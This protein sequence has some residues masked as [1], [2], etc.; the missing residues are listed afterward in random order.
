MR[1]S[2]PAVSHPASPR[3]A[4]AAVPLFANHDADALTRIAAVTQRRQFRRGEVIFHRG[5]PGASLYIVAAGRVKIMVPTDDG[6]EMVLT[7]MRPGDFFGE[8]ALLDGAPRSATAMALEA[9]TVWVLSREDLLGPLATTPAI[10][11]LLAVLAQR[12]RRTDL[13]VED[14]GYLDLD[15]RLARALL[16]LADEH[17]AEGPEGTVIDLPITQTDLAAM[18]GATRP[19]V[20]LLLGAYQTAGL[21]RLVGRAIVLRDLPALRVRA[22]LWV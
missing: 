12:L 7:V 14:L 2:Q 4:L 21:I 11:P 1:M 16:R 9:V 17:G 10:A 20:N 19:P 15:A 5:D 6:D 8:L 3:E 18:V 22:S 13:I